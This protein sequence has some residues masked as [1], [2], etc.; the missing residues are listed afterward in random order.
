MKRALYL[1][2]YGFS[3]SVGGLHGRGRPRR[4]FSGLLAAWLSL[5]GGAWATD[6]RVES[7]W[8]EALSKPPVA[9]QVVWLEAGARPV[10]ALFREA[11]PGAKG[12]VILAHEAGTHPNWP[13]VIAPLGNGLAGL[14]WASLSLQLPVPD[15][16]RPL[17]DQLYLF[18]EAVPR[19]RAA[20]EHLADQGFDNIA[21]IGHGLGAAMAAWYLAETPEPGPVTALVALS[22]PGHPGPA[23]LN[24]ANALARLNLPV[25][26]L[27]GER[28]QAHVRRGAP[29]RLR[30]AREAGQQT[31]T[32][33]GSA[34]T[35]KVRT[36]AM[37]RTGNA[38]FRQLAVSGADHFFRGHEA[39][40]LRRVRGW[41]D[42]YAKGLEDNN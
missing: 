14:G 9:G 5:S 18:D 11:G 16:E 32:V 20:V 30:A 15:F 10:F 4:W 13:Q 28:D 22:M 38:A 19:L 21:L 7:H 29:Q 35:A 31:P 17:A 42:N 41:L 40:L 8:A 36:L 37:N 1:I 33:M 2:G 34:R 39:R 25:L 12:A 3:A 24:G 23:R 6:Y 27:Y 26:D